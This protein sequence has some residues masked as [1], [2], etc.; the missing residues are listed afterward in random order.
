MDQTDRARFDNALQKLLY[1]TNGT[2]R[3]PAHISKTYWSVLKPLAWSAVA[4]GM[5]EALNTS[6][7]HVSPATLANFCRPAPGDVMA[8]AGESRAH[9]LEQRLHS[10]DQAADTAGEKRFGSLWF[11]SEFRDVL[12]VANMEFARRCTATIPGGIR[13]PTPDVYGYVG[14]FDYSAVVK[15]MQPAK[16]NKAN[17]HAAA[18]ECFW[19]VLGEEFT[20]YLD[21]QPEAL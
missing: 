6:T 3:V 16:G 10:A 12:R 9:A 5:T 2:A 15:A 20:I 14:P 13:I 21:T 18:W 1:A 19:C 17:D 8:A 11:E 7:G 4:L